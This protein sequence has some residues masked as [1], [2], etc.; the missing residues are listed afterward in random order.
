MIKKVLTLF[1]I[2]F[3][4]QAAVFA[5][6]RAEFINLGFAND[7]GAFLYGQF[8]KNESGTQLYADIVYHDL[9]SGENSSE[10]SLSKTYQDSQQSGSN[11]LSALLMN[12]K[13]YYTISTVDIDHTQTGTTLYFQLPGQK[14]GDMVS[15]SDYQTRTVYSVSFV[16]RPQVREPGTNTSLAITL[17]QTLKDGTQNR[18]EAGSFIKP[19][20]N[21]YD[22]QLKQIIVSPQRDY[23]VLVFQTTEYDE[24]NDTTNIRYYVDSV[25]IE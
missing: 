2:I 18:F 24:D 20:Q 13:E 16:M 5:G 19:I 22:F 21:V 8:G 1:L 7:S 4:I 25:N 3:C 9:V 10:L 17:F 6:D 15:F 11:G 14:T 23:V 12:L